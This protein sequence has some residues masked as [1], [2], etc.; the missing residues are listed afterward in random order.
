MALR[1]SKLLDDP[2]RSRQLGNQAR[3]VAIEMMSPKT[4][5]DI[6]VAS[7]ESMFNRKQKVDE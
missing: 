4:L 6:Q 5:T 1:A 2:E 3:R 7:Y